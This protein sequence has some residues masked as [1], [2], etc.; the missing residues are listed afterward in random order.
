M[1]GNKLYTSCYTYLVFEN[2]FVLDISRKL[3]PDKLNTRFE[4]SKFRHLK[5]LESSFEFW[6][7]QLIAQLIQRE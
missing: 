2:T 5:D 6:N 1:L 7:N 3:N 4:L